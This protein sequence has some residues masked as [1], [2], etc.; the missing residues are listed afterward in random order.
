LD[1]VFAIQD[2]ITL[3]IMDKLKVKLLGGEKATLAKHEIVDL[4]AYDIYLKGRYFWNKMTEEDLKRAIG[5][6]Q[7]AIE[8]TPNYA[9]AYAGLADSYCYLPI[10]GVA[11]SMQIY[12]KAR[13]AALKALEIDDTLAE[14][15]VSLGSI[16]TYHDWNWKG[17]EEDFT[18]AIE[19]RPDYALG[20][21]WY[22][23]YLLC[24]GRFDDAVSEMKRALELDPLSLVINRDLGFILSYSGRGEQAIEALLRTVEI[25]PNFPNTHEMLAWLYLNTSRYEEAKAAFE[26]E[27]GISGGR[28]PRTESSLASFY[29]LT[30]DKDKAQAILDDLLTRSK[31]TYVPAYSIA[32]VYIHLGEIEQGFKWLDKAYE[33]RDILLS[34]IKV[35]PEFA[36]LRN[37]PRYMALLKKIGLD[38]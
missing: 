12:P 34:H 30:D 36:E 33:E 37:D 17:A 24:L 13:E 31:R 4:E 6:F 38:T 11:P 19:L 1:D 10:Y 27:I 29:A 15:Y 35:G 32:G 8:K 21:H 16:K 7:Q 25:D 3:A 22:A 28:Y 9:P 18:R 2:E 26:K 14:A 20:H 5:Y 23:M